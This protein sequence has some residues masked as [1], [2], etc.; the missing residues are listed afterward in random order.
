[1]LAALRTAPL[2]E[3]PAGA[4]A[5][6]ALAAASGKMAVLA[7]ILRRVASVPGDRVVVVAGWTSTLDAVAKLCA[8]L[9]LQ[10]SRLDGSTPIDARADVVRRFN[11]GSGGIVFLLSTRA[12]G[13]GINLCGANRLVLFDSDWNPA[14]DAQALGRVWR[15]GQRKPVAL[16]RLLT[17]GS[18]EEKIY[19]RQLLKGEMAALL[20]SEAASRHFSAE[21][22]RRLFAF[23]PPADGAAGCETAQLLAGG[24]GGAALA[25]L[26]R[27]AAA[28][29]ADE[30]L[31]DAVAAGAVSFVHAPPPEGSAAALA[32]A[33][34]A[35]AADADAAAEAESDEADAAEAARAAAEDLAAWSDDD[36]D[37]DDDDADADGAAEAE[38]ELAAGPQRRRLRRK[39]DADGAFVPTGAAPFLDDDDDA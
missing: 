38:A 1:V 19:Q 30:P 10:T 20:Q 13:V 24:A 21:E 23:R 34:E 36:D 39:A 6:G 31:A 5:A 33:A 25:A 26:W 29:V 35:A 32:A 9:A 4:D 15:D 37:D 22:L 27:D 28:D 16:Y 17:A 7:S 18:I 11:G 14:H 8:A 12:G 3:L 2:P